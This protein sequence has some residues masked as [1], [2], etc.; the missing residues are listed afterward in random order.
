MVILSNWNFLDFLGC[1]DHLS[2]L[3]LNYNNI[4]LLEKANNLSKIFKIKT[5][6]EKNGSGGSKIECTHMQFRARFCYHVNTERCY[7]I[8]QNL[9]EIV[10]SP[11]HY[12]VWPLCKGE[13][14]RTNC[15]LNHL[16]GFILPW[17]GKVLKCLDC[18]VRVIERKWHHYFFSR[19][20]DGIGSG[21]LL[22]IH[23]YQISNLN[24]YYFIHTVLP[25]KIPNL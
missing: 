9:V 7:F 6:I 5:F 1:K 10:L 12:W 22:Q 21:F 23:H 14:G 25:L 4:H 11:P 17:N 16:S 19:I 24:C 18:N 3:E 20:S 8:H 15:K 2:T 13:F